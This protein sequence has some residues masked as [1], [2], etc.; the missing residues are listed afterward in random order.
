M[1][2]SINLSATAVGDDDL[3]DLIKREVSSLQVDPGFISVEVS[4]TALIADLAKARAFFQGLKDLGFLI[5]LDNFGGGFSSLSRLKEIPADYLKI[6][7]SFVE[8]IS[9]N[10]KDR[11]FVR[12]ISDL[13]T[14][15]GIGAVAESIQDAESVAILMDLGV[16]NGQG[17][18]LG[19][20]QPIARILEKHLAVPSAA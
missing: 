4:E 19:E 20:A 11:H 6:D 8:N 5:A 13:A 9:R 12:A 2:I 18:Y 7:G 16:L 14:G 3:F 10:A 17:P 15:L 1:K